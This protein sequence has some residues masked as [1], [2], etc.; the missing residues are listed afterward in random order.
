MTESSALPTYSAIYAF[1][2]SLSDAGNLSITTTAAGAPEPVSPPYYQQNYGLVPGTV[3]SNG[4]TWV[5]D[6]SIALGLGTLA[7]SLAG[8][9]DF[10]FGGAETGPTPQNA[11]DRAILAISLQSQLTQFQAAVPKPSANALYTLS[12]GSN[13]VLGILATNGL[14]KTQQDADVSAA[15]VNEIGFVKSLLAEG[16]KTLS[17]LDVPDL[18]KTPDIT[19]GLVN[20]SDTPSAALDREAARLSSLYDTTLTSQLASL[21]ATDGVAIHVI[22]AYSLIDKT[23]ADP[24]AYGLTN[25][26]SPVWS[27]SFTSASSGTLAATT[28]A[29][30][31]QYLFFDKLHPTEAGH[32]ATAAA[33]EQQLSN[34]TPSTIGITPGKLNLSK[35]LPFLES[36]ASALGK[37]GS[38]ALSS[39]SREASSVLGLTQADFTH[40]LKTVETALGS[41]ASHIPTTPSL[42]LAD[43]TGHVASDISSLTLH[44]RL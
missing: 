9:T 44:A 38:A 40:L 26:T 3:F 41:A 13:D 43:L 33:A 5:Q 27:G 35:V 7:P 34:P 11:N 37:D 23:V 31:N 24:A 30:Q 20:G 15:V 39:L 32:L 1:G 25:V 14:S 28:T 8:G 10:A 16:A 18:S 6:L 36:V 4:P 21:A 17:V 29:A 42:S 22:D 19:Q 12:I 2:D